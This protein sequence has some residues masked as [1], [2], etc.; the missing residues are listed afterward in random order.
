MR[1]KLLGNSGLRVSELCLG[2]M[3][4]GED[5]GWGADKEESRA[6]F[7]AFAEA[8]GNFL[9]T[10]NIYTNGTSETLVGEFVKGDRE[11][12][13]IAT[14][15]SLNTRPGDV[16]ACGNH[17]KNL[18]QAVEA[19]LKRLGTDYID[20]LWLH[21]WDSLTPMEEVMR[22]FDDLVRMGKVLYIG[23]SDSPA[24]I[25]SQANTLATLRGW[26]PFIGLQIEYS[27]KE[28]TPERELLPMAKALNI[29]VTAWS[30]L[31]GGVLTGKYNQPN[32]VDGRLSMTDQPFQILDRDLKIA[33]TVLEIAR[34][35]GKSPAQVALN[36]LRN[37]PNPIIPI[38]GARRLSQLQDNLA[39]VDFNLTGEQLQRLDNISAISLGFPQEL[40]ASQFVRDILLGGVA[41]QLDR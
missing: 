21:I 23:I 31:G 41:A 26:T 16:N 17:R 24:W 28:R 2:T 30:P 37:R 3:T 5:W 33:E 8:G 12:W 36:W 20:L 34:E 40:L 1:Y 18:F 35:I 19:S 10:A 22:A 9:D 38:I 27:L 29:G 13:V 25:V 11:K 15:Y 39:C 4:F 32:P 14:K 7:Q 6:V